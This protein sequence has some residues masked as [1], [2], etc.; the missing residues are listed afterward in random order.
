MRTLFETAWVKD[1]WSP[2]LGQ[3]AGT[4]TDWGGT[5]SKGIT[6][7]VD[8]YQ[9]YAGTEK[10]EQDRKAAE[11]QAEAIKAQANAQA[12][13]AAAA[14]MNQPKKILGMSPTTAAIVG[15]A[16]LAAIIGVVMLA[17]KK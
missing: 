11:A 13:A 9:A 14:A 12:A 6:E 17:K 15:V 3:A 4:S 2:N 10:A 1:A 5:I 7:G 8:A 16:G